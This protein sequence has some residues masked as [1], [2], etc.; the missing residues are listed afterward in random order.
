MSKKVLMV[1][2]PDGFRDA[3][4]LDPRQVLEAAGAEI[5]VASLVTGESRGVEGTVAKIDLTVDQVKVEDF[6]AVIFVG[7]PGMVGLVGDKRLM[8]LAKA[9]YQ[10]GKLTTGICAATGILANANLLTDKKATGWAG[11]QQIIS[12]HGGSYTGQDVEMD[13]KIITGKG[14]GAAKAFGQKIAGSLK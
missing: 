14:P 5:K 9:F 4:Y 11:V 2:A 1:V 6:D 13:G 10:A 12:S 3:E 7:G 8:T